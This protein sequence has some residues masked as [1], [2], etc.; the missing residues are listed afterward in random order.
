MKLLNF[1]VV[2]LFLS[3]SK[4]SAQTEIDSNAYKIEDVN[5]SI[6]SMGNEMPLKLT[7]GNT[8]VIGSK[9]IEKLPVQTT[10]ELL[11]YVIGLDLRQRGASGVQADIGIQGSS[12]DQVLVLINGMRRCVCKALG[13]EGNG[14]CG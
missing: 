14:R 8:Q 12:F 10:N 1:G 11:F 9:E 4:L 7:G 3:M 6:R 13:T 2:V 5:V